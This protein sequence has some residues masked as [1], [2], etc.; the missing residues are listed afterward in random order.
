LRPALYLFESA[1]SGRIFREKIGQPNGMVR[2]IHNGV[3][4]AEF[5]PVIAVADATDLIFVGE[6]RPVK[7]IDILIDAIARLHEAGRTVTAT[8]VGSGPDEGALKAQVRRMSL[9]QAIRFLPAMPAR[10]ALTLGRIMVIPSR[11]ESLPYVVLETAAAGKPLITTNVGGIP[12]ICGSLSY[13]LIEAGNAEA[14]ADAIARTLDDPAAALEFAAALRLRVASSFSVD[15]MVDG[16][17]SAYRQA[18][19]QTV[20]VPEAALASK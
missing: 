8:L 14:L 9:D 17:I 2:V 5:E 1:Y 6:M 16:V 4:Q 20:A 18:M 19:A 12:E 15:A 7:G 11:A 10:E 3:S 13:A